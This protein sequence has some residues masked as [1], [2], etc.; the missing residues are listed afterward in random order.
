MTYRPNAVVETRFSDQTDRI[1]YNSSGRM[2]I[3]IH[4]GDHGLPKNHTR[5]AHGE[6]AHEFIYNEAGKP[7]GRIERELTD[8]ERKENGDIL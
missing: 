3:Q 2:A 5:G 8:T 6:H 1:Y 4:S 7:S